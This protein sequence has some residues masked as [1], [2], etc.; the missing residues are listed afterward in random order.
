MSRELKLLVISDTH[1]ERLEQLPAPLREELPRADF[2]VHAGDYTGAPL[3]RA[4]LSLR[5]FYGVYGNLDG[6][7]VRSLLKPSALIELQGYRIGICHPHVGGPPSQAPRRALELLGERPDVLIFGHT[8]MPVFEK[9][10]DIWLLNP[11]SATGT[12]PASRR[13]YA[14]LTLGERVSCSIV[15]L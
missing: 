8:H 14:L 10:E 9:G 3:A 7:E 1:C 2:V 15:E 11:G 4:L 6:P 13:T 5:N 12:W